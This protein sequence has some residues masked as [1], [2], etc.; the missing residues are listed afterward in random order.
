[1]LGPDQL[2]LLPS[3][4]PSCCLDVLKHYEVGSTA[5]TSGLDRPSV[6]Q[7]PLTPLEELDK[8]RVLKIATAPAKVDGLVRPGELVALHGAAVD[9]LDVLES[10]GPRFRCIDGPGVNVEQVNGSIH[11]GEKITGQPTV[12]T[13]YL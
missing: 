6:S 2:A 9:M 3:G 7:G 12:S 8:G 4:L 5:R 10:K 11:L 1:M 13:R